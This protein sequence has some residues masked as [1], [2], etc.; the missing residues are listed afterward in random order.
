VSAPGQPLILYAISGRWSFV[1]ID[2]AIL[3]ERWRV[4]D[5]YQPGRMPDLLR[6]V[7]AVARA[8][9][10]FAWFASWHS[11]LPI[12]L[13]WLFRKP[14]VLVV[15]GFDTADMPWIDYGYQRGGFRRW[16]SRLVM[17]R[18]GL[19]VTN[20]RYSRSEIERNTGI[21]ADRVTV[22]H[23][24]VPDDFGNLPE[25]DRR[26]AVALTV[27]HLAHNTL[28]QKGHRP[29]VDAAA[30]LP[31]V[32]FV[33]VGRWLDDA[34]G[35]LRARAGQNVVFTGFVDDDERDGWYRRAGCYVQ[36]SH[37]EG[38]GMAVAEAMLAGCIPV[39][40]DTT[41]MPEV[42][43][44]AG[45]LINAPE[46]AAIAAGVRRAL[47]MDAQARRRARDRILSEFPVERRRD[48][49]QRVVEQALRGSGE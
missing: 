49:I 9:M 14:S 6:V 16:A 8:D 40:V 15:G 32:R 3:A 42:V 30:L 24:G 46:P 37:H 13:A 25:E 48:A 4:R 45:I 34:I 39:V 28:E 22:V 36:A 18:A 31:D 12:L 33:F 26:E 1:Q 44:D 29:F 10:V 35:E 11:F 19:L 17:R 43:G 47:A 7:P 38:F 20:S 2:R 41:A 27:G 5:W 23:H 21:P